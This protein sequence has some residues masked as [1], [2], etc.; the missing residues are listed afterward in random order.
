MLAIG[1]TCR[2]YVAYE[3]NGETKYVYS[4][5]IERS[6][7]GVNETILN[8][9]TIASDFDGA[10]IKVQ[11]RNGNTINVDVDLRDTAEDWFYWCFK[12]ENAGGMTLTFNFPTTVR[13]GY[14]GA[15]VSY[16]YENW[17]WQYEDTGHEG[18]TFT[19]TFGVN[20]NSV[21]FAHDMLYRPERF[22]EF[23]ET[24]NL[25]VKILCQS[26]HGTDVP[27][28]EF[29]NGSEVMVLTARHH[30][31]EST[32]SYV[33]EGVLEEMLADEFF[34]NN[35]KVICVP[36]VDIDGVIK[37]DQGKLRTPHDHNRD[38]GSSATAI[39]PSVSKL[40]E[41]AETKTVKYAFDFH[42]P[43]HLGGANDKVFFP[44][45]TQSIVDDMTT[46]S[47][48]FENCISEDSENTFPYNKDNNTLPTA[49]DAE[50]ITSFAKYFAYNG[51]ELTTAPETPYFNAGGVKFTP[52]K[53]INTGK[54]FAKA[55]KDYTQ[56]KLIADN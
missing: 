16:D 9:I 20:E 40:C 45:R 29:G 23:A 42:S 35:Y 15:A 43:W 24:N 21:Y 27:Y 39:Y 36:M 28:V 10:N 12:V 46:F 55:I 38:Y 44:I 47:T 37:G 1:V 7:N 3:E 50:S 30:A 56:K 18:N 11:S 19:Y 32:G 26:E 49:E 14:Y 48:C 51:A 5:A 2:M 17:Y 53:A 22:M 6:Y 52:E 33:L 8:G 4:D 25:E 31:C 41:I 54:A 13:V 34:T